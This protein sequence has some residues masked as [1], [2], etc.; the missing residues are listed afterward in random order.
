MEAT[1]QNTH[2]STPEPQQETKWYVL[3]VVSGKSVRLKNTLIKKL[4]RGGGAKL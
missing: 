3:R 4:S 1:T 2:D